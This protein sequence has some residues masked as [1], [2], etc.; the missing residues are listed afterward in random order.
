MGAPLPTPLINL[1]CPDCGGKLETAGQDSY[2]CSSCG[3]VHRLRDHPDWL[4]SLQES[5]DKLKSWLTS[6]PSAARAATLPQALPGLLASLE[7]VSDALRSRARA[8]FVSLVVFGLGYFLERWL[9][10]APP[11]AWMRYLPIAI[12]LLGGL[13]ILYVAVRLI[14]LLRWRRQ[15]IHQIERCRDAIRKLGS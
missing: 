15:L 8:V 12:M 2:I 5:L 14:L 3:A 10:F 11:V 1:T 9:I 7:Q 4:K 13:A 6:P